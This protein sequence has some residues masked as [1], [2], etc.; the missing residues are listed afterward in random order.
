MGK[1]N[2]A[3]SRRGTLHRRRW[4]PNWEGHFFPERSRQLSTFYGANDS[5]R[6]Q[7]FES[8]IRLQKFVFLKKIHGYLVRDP[9]CQADQVNMGP[10]PNIQITFAKM[11]ICPI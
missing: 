11:N 9:C 1:N 6:R 10:D 2:V 5:S 8:A 3:Y 4:S 7:L